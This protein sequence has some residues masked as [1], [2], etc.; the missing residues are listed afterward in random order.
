[1]GGPAWLPL[2][3]EGAA[4]SEGGLGALNALAGYLATGGPVVVPLLVMGAALW[5][6]VTLRAVALRRGFAATLEPAQLT[7]LLRCPPAPG[8]APL[9]ELLRRAPEA[10][11]WPPGE[12]RRLA[13]QLLLL[14]LR[15]PLQRF[16]GAIH[17][18]ALAAPLLGLL[19]T[20]SGM[21]ETFRSLVQVSALAPAGGGV[22][23]GISQALVTTQLGLLVAVPGLLAGRLL[24]RREARLAGELEQVERWLRG[25]PAAGGE[26]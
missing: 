9:S 15:P 11:R 23:A 12:A 18:I 10:L 13:L 20:V 3:A 4:A 17:A 22:A 26:R 2:A 6:L 19:G 21:I 5:Y 16:G 8:S 7:R 25:L 24:A 14:E 1:M